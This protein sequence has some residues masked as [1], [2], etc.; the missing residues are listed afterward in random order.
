MVH[1]VL[2]LLPSTQEGHFKF[3]SKKLFQ[4]AEGS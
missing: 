4:I 3:W 1:G 2:K